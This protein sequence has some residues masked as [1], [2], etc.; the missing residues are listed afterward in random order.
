MRTYMYRNYMYP[1][2][3]DLCTWDVERIAEHVSV[4]NVQVLEE[5]QR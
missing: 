1:P 5:L 3:F 4:G 2:R